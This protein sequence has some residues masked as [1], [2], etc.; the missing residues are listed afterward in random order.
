MHWS[1]AIS[2]SAAA[3]FESE[4]FSATFVWGARSI[5]GPAILIVIL[6]TATWLV[7]SVVRAARAWTPID[8]F[9]RRIAQRPA[10]CASN[11]WSSIRFVF[12]EIGAFG[13]AVAIGVVCWR[14][15]D[16]LT[17]WSNFADTM[18]AADLA[19]LANRDRQLAF[20]FYGSLLIVLLGFLLVHVLLQR[21]RQ[22]MTRAAARCF[23]LFGRP[24]RGGRAERRALPPHQRHRR[25]TSRPERSPMLCDRRE[26]R[27]RAA[28]APICRRRAIASSR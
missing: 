1:L 25:G 6:L 19:A 14:F 2:R 24:R 7:T 9:V 10:T 20:P 11:D 16:L 28:S 22:K 5:V 13:G 23:R 8:R 3:G 4:P 21:S 12:A 27:S 15:R 18:P 26:C 17:A